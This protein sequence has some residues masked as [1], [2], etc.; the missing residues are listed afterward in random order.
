MACS[1]LTRLFYFSFQDVSK[2]VDKSAL[3]DEKY[4]ETLNRQQQI[5][6]K[7]AELSKRINQVRRK[8]L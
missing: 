2:V 8:F 1:K 4:R 7:F 5:E 6:R 3:A